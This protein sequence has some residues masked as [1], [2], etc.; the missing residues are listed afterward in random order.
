MVY[1]RFKTKPEDFIVEEITKDGNIC[2]MNSAGRNIP[3][4]QRFSL[5]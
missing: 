5:V 3:N 2:S 4:E 1:A